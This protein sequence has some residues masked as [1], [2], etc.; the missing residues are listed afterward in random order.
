MLIVEDLHIH[1]HTSEHDRPVHA[2]DGISLDLNDGES[3]GIVGETGS[4]KST[5]ALSLMGLVNGASI[6]GKVS[7]YGESLPLQDENAMRQIRWR[8]IAL[9]FQTSG[10]AFDPVYP[11][12]K[13]IIEPMLVHLDLSQNQAEAKA[14]QLLGQV[15]LKETLFNHFP[16]QLSGGEKKRAMVAMA[17]SCDPQLLILDE[18]TT[19]LDLLS[20][21]SLIE[22]LLDLRADRSMGLIVISH[23]LADIAR[24]ADRTA[25]FYAGHMVETGLT[26]KLLEEPCHPYTFGLLNAYPLMGRAKDLSGIRGSLPDPAHPLPGCRFH[27][28]CTQVVE[29]CLDQKPALQPPSSGY[30]DRQRF[31]ACHLGGLQTLLSLEDLSKTFRNGRSDEIPAV[32]QASLFIREGEVVGLVGQSGSGKTTLARLVVG[33]EKRD[34]GKVLFEGSELDVRRMLN[35]GSRRIQMIFQDPFEALSTRMK[36]QE[37]VQEPLDIQGIGSSHERMKKVEQALEAVSL[38]TTDEF[39]GRHTH[40]LSGGQLQRI[41]IARALVLE[42]KLILA[43]EPVSMLDASEQAKIILLLKRIQNERGMGLLLISHDIALVRKVADRIVVMHEG[44]IVEQGSSQR[45]L[46][47]PFHPYTRSLV[48]ASQDFDQIGE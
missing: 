8:R 48:D 16:H 17:L 1:Y 4:G 7:F 22:L 34:G 23:D 6:K 32:R 15:G 25:V 2:L 12:G 14:R 3:L 36:V 42:P 21:R 46:N 30:S 13:Q 31:V 26:Q 33:L 5:F 19:G 20:R 41:A 39:L 44:E 47:S 45:V 37:L 27:P 10:S 28:R 9:A 11:I 38:P 35:G 29:R 43:D 24:L 18:P 40:E